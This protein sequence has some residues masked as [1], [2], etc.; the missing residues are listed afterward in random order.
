MIPTGDVR[1]RTGR[2]RE[3]SRKPM[4]GLYWIHRA[5]YQFGRNAV[6]SQECQR[7]AKDGR[8]S[9]E[10]EEVVLRH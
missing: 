10:G 1:T 3:K 8:M 2:S 5:V 6:T 4:A 9:K 7:V